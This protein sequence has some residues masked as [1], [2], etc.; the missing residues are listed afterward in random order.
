MAHSPKRAPEFEKLVIG[1]LM[2]LGEMTTGGHTMEMIKIIKQATNQSY[3]TITRDLW[4]NEGFLGLYKGFLP[5][6]A[7]QMVKGIPVLFIQAESDHQ[8]KKLG[9]GAGVAETLAGVLGGIGQGVFM[10]PTQRLKTI[11]MTDP[12]YSGAAA[13][14]SISQAFKMTTIVA[15]DVVKSDGVG[16]LF[17]GLGPMMYK[18][19]CDW[20]LRFWGVAA[21]KDFLT[22]NDPKKKLS[23]FEK[24]AVGFFG[25]A[26]S[27]LTMPFDSWVSNCQ[28][29]SKAGA[30]MSSMDVAR[31][32][33]RTNGVHSFV[34][35]WSMRLIHAGYHT[36]W[37]TTIGQMIFEAIR[38]PGA[39][40]GH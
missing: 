3:V 39:S 38:G 5:W 36:M 33:W 8:L 13:P 6:G 30:K 2:V 34:R 15:Y 9:V 22:R 28:K 32:M 27:T 26:V 23:T 10:T 31:E 12:K 4:R 29:A 40:G 16:T 25:G 17:K 24:L 35:G 20:G 19:G 37:M 1:P 18:R 11:V 21:A 14:K 7:L